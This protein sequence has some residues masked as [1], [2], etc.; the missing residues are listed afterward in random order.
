MA[1]DF[2]A[3]SNWEAG[4]AADW[5]AMEAGPAAGCCSLA[6]WGV[7]AGEAGAY[8]GPEGAD[9]WPVDSRGLLHCQ[10]FLP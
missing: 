9:C 8:P 1:S 4:F 7:E 6:H 2:W 5:A 10:H 3:S